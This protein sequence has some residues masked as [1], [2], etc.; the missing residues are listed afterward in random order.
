MTMRRRLLALHA[1]AAEWFH[2]NLMKKPSA[3][4]AR[5][6]LKSRGIGGE[7]AKVWQIGY[8]PESWD[9]IR[10]LRDERGYRR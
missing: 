10:D 3:Q 6:Y 8:A 2:D 4:P 1:E 9:A 7:I 5:D